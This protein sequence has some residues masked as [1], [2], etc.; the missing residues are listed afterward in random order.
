MM[1]V[2]VG[3]SPVQLR[4][5]FRSSGSES[6]LITSESPL[7]LALAPIRYDLLTNYCIQFLLSFLLS[8]SFVEY[9]IIIINKEVV[10][11][12]S[13]STIAH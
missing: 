4:R 5:L 7:A 6:K 1:V 3:R 13:L 12:P 10:P 2:T 8:S 11:V 9:T